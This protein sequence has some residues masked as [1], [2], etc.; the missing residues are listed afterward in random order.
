VSI[1]IPTYNR[2]G[3]LGAALDSARRQTHERLE[4]VISDNASDDGTEELCRRA[5]AED[6]RIRYVR[7]PVNRGPTPNFNWLFDALEAPYVLMLADDDWIDDDYVEV[8][9]RELRAR[10][11]HVLVAGLAHYYRDGEKI[12]EGANVQVDDADP[13]ARVLSYY[14]QVDDNGTF[15]GVMPREVLRAAAPMPNDLGNDWFHLAAIAFQGKMLTLPGPNIHRDASGTS[16]TLAG[17]LSMFGSDSTAQARAPHLFMAAYAGREILTAPVYAP[18]SPP[19]RLWL[20]LRAMPLI[21]DAKSLAWHL[22]APTFANLDRRPRGRWLAR[23]F[24]ALA[25][26]LGAGNTRLG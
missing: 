19:A 7:H 11:H 9:L 16:E 10:P 23:A 21:V 17:V 3:T 12:A 26:R 18:L 24:L 5:A 6:P 8:C 20:A 4:I 14:R 13:A 25:K 1:G 15:Y 22:V 2:V